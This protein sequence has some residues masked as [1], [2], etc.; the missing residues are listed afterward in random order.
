MHTDQVVKWLAKKPVKSEYFFRLAALLS[1]YVITD[2][3]TI[4][5]AYN[6]RLAKRP[7]FFAPDATPLVVPDGASAPSRQG[8]GD[9]PR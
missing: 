6:E 1:T 8:G 2:R 5:Q 4:E 3:I 9:V 7:D